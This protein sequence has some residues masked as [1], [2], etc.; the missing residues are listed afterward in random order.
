MQARAEGGRRQSECR[1]C[2]A[3]V[4]VPP[5]PTFADPIGDAPVAFRKNG[6]TKSTW[7]DE[8]GSTE[9]V[10]PLNWGVRFVPCTMAFTR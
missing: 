1:R 8:D 10:V 9:F 7:L 5:T 4:L 6:V 3:I 2:R